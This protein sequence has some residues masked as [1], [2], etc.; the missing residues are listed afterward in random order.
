MYFKVILHDKLQIS[1]FCSFTHTDIKNE[2]RLPNTLCTLH[3]CLIQVAAL[4]CLNL[5]VPLVKSA[6]LNPHFIHL[7]FFLNNGD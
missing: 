4:T 7:F 2:T 5:F 3:K 6:C 1:Q